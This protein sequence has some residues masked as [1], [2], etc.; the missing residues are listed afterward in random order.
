MHPDKGGN[1]EDFRTLNSFE[2][3]IGD[4][5]QISQNFF[6]KLIDSNLLLIKSLAYKASTICKVIDTGLDTARVIYFP[7]FDNAKKLA[8]DS[9]YLCSTYVGFNFYSSIMG[10]GEALYSLFQGDYYKSLNILGSTMGYMVLPTLISETG[11]PYLDVGYAVGMSIY[12]SYYTIVNVY[13]FYQEYNN[14]DA[15]LKSMAAY[16]ELATALSSSVLQHLYDFRSLRKEYDIKIYN[17]VLNKEEEAI[18]ARLD[19]EGEFGQKLYQYVYGPLIQEKKNL[20]F[21]I[22]KGELSEEEAA[23][24]ETK[25]AKISFGDQSYE[26]CMQ[27]KAISNSYEEHYYCHNHKKTVLDHLMVVLNTQEINL[28]EHL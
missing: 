7:T 24:L 14:A 18:K 23:S 22:L 5:N 25:H 1:A 15:L 4:L 17:I 12:S 13:S 28:I 11:I 8:L 3:Q 9:G 20:S 26:H 2:E 21:K 16:K 6:T 10:G 27:I 19:E